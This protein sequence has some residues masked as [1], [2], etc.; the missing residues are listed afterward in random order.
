MGIPVVAICDTNTRIRNMDLVIPSNNKGKNSLALIYWIL[1]KEIL[2][3]RG[4]EFN[5]PVEE[6]I[7]KIEPQPYLLELQEQQK[8]RR[9]SRRRAMKRR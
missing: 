3:K 2:K 8:L 9:Q 6:F 4:I 5:A 7:S 1:T